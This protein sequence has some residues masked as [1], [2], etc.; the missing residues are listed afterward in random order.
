MRQEDLRRMGWRDR[1]QLGAGDGE[2]GFE[3]EVEYGSVPLSAGVPMKARRRMGA[4][5]VEED[6]TV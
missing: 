1:V 5:C 6:G 2:S 3:G 4:D